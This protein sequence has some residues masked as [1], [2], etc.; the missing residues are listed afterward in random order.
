[1]TRY[2]MLREEV[3]QPQIENLEEEE[4]EEEEEHE[5]L[6][7]RSRDE[8]TVRDRWIDAVEKVMENEGFERGEKHLRRDLHRVKMDGDYGS[9]EPPRWMN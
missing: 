8:E 9:N 5:M 3:E 7:G 1:M 2:V 4:N 6:V